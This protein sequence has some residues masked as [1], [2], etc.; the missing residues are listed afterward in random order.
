M[1]EL[2]VALSELVPSDLKPDGF[3]FDGPFRYD[4]YP[5]VPVVKY[6][7]RYLMGDGHRRAMKLLLDGIEH[8]WIKLLQTDEDVAECNDG[9]FASFGSISSFVDWTEKAKSSWPVTIE[10]ID[11][12]F[13]QYRGQTLLRPMYD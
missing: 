5:A 10:S 12:Y 8:I 1:Q 4:D 7:N 6:G 2:E 13:I 9:S 11:D 3:K